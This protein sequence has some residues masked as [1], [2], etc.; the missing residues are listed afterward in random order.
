LTAQV[1]Y[2]DDGR[3]AQVHTIKE[4]RR[5]LQLDEEHGIDSFDFY[6]RGGVTPSE[7]IV[8][9]RKTLKRLARL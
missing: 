3:D 1:K 4:I 9:Y 8:R 2:A 7:F 5:R 6:Q